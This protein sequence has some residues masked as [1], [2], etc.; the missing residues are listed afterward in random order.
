MTSWP[1]SASSAAATDESTPPDIATTIRM[2]A[3][4]PG[5]RRHENTKIHEEN[6]MFSSCVS[7]CLRVF[8]VTVMRSPACCV[9]PRSFSTRRGSTSTTRS[10]S[11]CVENMPEAEAQRVLRAVRRQAHRLQH[12]RRLERARRA[13]RS[14]RH[15]DAFEI[16]RDQQA[17]GLDALEADVGRVRHARLARA[18][19]RGARHRA[20]GCPPRADRAAPPTRVAFGRHLAARQRAP[21]RPGRRSPATFSVPARRL[22]SCLPPVIVGC[23]RVPRLI[24]SAP[25]PFGPLNLCAESDSRST[26]SARTSTGILPDRL[27]RVGVHQRAVL[28]RDRARA[29]RPAESCRSRCWRASPRRARCRR[30]SPRAADRA[31]RCRMRSTGSSVVRQPR[32]ASALQRVEHRFVLDA[33]GDQMAASG[34]LERLGGAANREVV[35]LGAAAREH[36]LRRIAVDQRGDRRSR[37]VERRLGLLAEVM[38]ARRV[39][40]HV[41]RSP[42][43]R[44]R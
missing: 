42:G 33:A 32:R 24:H 23:I 26:P 29:P 15:G 31:R 37:V 43:P 20:R 25:A 17:L 44:P 11:S 16:E 3:Y 39:A 36:D 1:C 30:R 7:S 40:E 8:V 27:H 35:R 5:P 38:D 10:T 12:V 6:A 34:R 9:R 28:V 13:G 21:R 18:V 19:D 2:S 41:A 22:R 4:S 14:G